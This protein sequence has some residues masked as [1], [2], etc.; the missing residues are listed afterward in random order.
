LRKDPVFRP[1]NS[2]ELTIQGRWLCIEWLKIKPLLGTVGLVYS[3]FFVHRLRY[4]VG[5]IF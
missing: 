1:A 5:R 2:T 4:R 3:G